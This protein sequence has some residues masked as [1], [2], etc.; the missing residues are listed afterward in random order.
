MFKDHVR[1]RVIGKSEQT[2]KYDGIKNS[3]D[4]GGDF[5]FLARGSVIIEKPVEPEAA[6]AN[7]TGVITITSNVSNTKVYLNGAYEG[8]APVTKTLDTGDYEIEVKK[9]GYMDGRF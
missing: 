8:Q 3:G 1:N 6:P 7:D 2:P 9:D 4:E 5:I